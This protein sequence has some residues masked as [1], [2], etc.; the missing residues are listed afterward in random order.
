MVSIFSI[1]LLAFPVAAVWVRRRRGVRALWILTALTV[2]ATVA[3]ACWA[4]SKAG[5]NRLVATHGYAPILGSMMRF[6]VAGILVPVVAASVVAAA[7]KTA[8]HPAT[9][10]W[11]AALAMILATVGGLVFTA[12]T[13]A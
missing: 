11:L 8:V 1:A 5:G 9:A 3:L 7:T 12:F 2:L 10:Y 13:L 4:S 6:A